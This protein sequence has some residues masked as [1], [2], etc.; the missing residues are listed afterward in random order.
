MK[1]ALIELENAEPN[2]QTMP[3]QGDGNNMRLM[4]SQQAM[5]SVGLKPV[6]VDERASLTTRRSKFYLPLYTLIASL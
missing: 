5:E 4:S 6:R 1:V 2:Q 3:L